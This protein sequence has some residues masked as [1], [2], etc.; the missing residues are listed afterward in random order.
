MAQGGGQA[1]TTLH[2][3]DST[4]TISAVL[5]NWDAFGPHSHSNSNFLVI[6]WHFRPCGDRN[7]IGTVLPIIISSPYI[8]Q[9]A[10]VHA[11]LAHRVPFRFV[12]Y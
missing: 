1:P 5:S 10:L 12:D 4:T 7:V 11:V 8:S 3:L 6:K 2:P 9:I